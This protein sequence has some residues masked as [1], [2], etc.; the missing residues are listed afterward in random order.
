MILCVKLHFAQFP[1]LKISKCICKLAHAY[2]ARYLNEF[3]AMMLRQTSDRHQLITLVLLISLFNN[4]FNPH[5]VYEKV[6]WTHTL[7]GDGAKADDTTFDI[8]IIKIPINIKLCTRSAFSYPSASSTLYRLLKIRA[9]ATS[10]WRI[11]LV[12]ISDKLT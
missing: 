2:L 7:T 1:Y 10:T 3:L 8:V 6:Q 12:E 11:K 9:I 4:L 5:V